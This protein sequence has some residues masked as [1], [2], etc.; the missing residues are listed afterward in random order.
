MIIMPGVTVFGS[1]GWG[2]VRGSD[3][4]GFNILVVEK[5]NEV[6]GEIVMMQ[7]RMGF[8]SNAQQRPEPFSFDLQELEREL[9]LIDAMHI[10]KTNTQEFDVEYLREFVA[11][12]V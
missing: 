1:E 8:P 3:G 11:S 5:T 2:S 10:Y 4:G 9:Q 6:Y 12:Y 7:N